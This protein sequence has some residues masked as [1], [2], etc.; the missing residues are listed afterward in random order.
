M[1]D[2]QQS[3]N[4]TPRAPRRAAEPE[5][6]K[7][8]RRG[9]SRG[10]AVALLVA[11]VLGG[12][13]G[14]FAFRARSNR[15]T[16]EVV[17]AVNGDTITKDEFLNRLQMAGG[18]QVLRQLV[19]E[20]LMLQFA[21]EKGYLP[22]DQQV[23]ARIAELMKDPAFAA[24]VRRGA[25]NKGELRKRVQLQMCQIGGLQQ[26]MQVSEEDI[27]R[28]YRQNTDPRNPIAR[29]YQPETV[30]IAVI[31]TPTEGA[32]KK[33]LQDLAVK[34]PWA[35]VVRKYSKD[36]SRSNDG[37]LPPIPRGRTRSAKIPG[38]EATIFGMKVGDMKGPVKMAGAWW[39]IR[40]LDKTP[41]K[42]QTYAQAREEAKT[43]ALLMKGIPANTQKLQKDYAEFQRKARIQAFWKQYADAVRMAQ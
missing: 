15:Q 39:V 41:A 35:D 42:T 28:Y 13:V 34:I 22:T 32:A 16:H 8:A 25:V 6:A 14:A 23:E 40:C 24:N 27:Q 9:V 7:R 36:R 11:F 18:A 19:G 20:R 12:V 43:G 38:M 10:T 26:G 17:V 1:S 31:V 29:F 5:Q 30:R 37:L 33:A 2:P 21:K 3:N 4:I